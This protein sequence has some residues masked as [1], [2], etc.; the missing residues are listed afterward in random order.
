M[1]AVTP[2][3]RQ[4]AAFGWLRLTLLAPDLIEAIL[5]GKQRAQWSFS[6]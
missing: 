3:H 6:R 4:H 5:D 1:G 2:T